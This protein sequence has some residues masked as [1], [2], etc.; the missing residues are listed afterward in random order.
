M[1]LFDPGSS[2]L[3]PQLSQVPTKIVTR[4]WTY[5]LSLHCRN[6]T[7]SM[8]LVTR[9]CLQISQMVGSSS[10]AIALSPRRRPSPVTVTRSSRSIRKDLIAIGSVVIELGQKADCSRGRNGEHSLSAGEGNEPKRCPL[11]GASGLLS[12]YDPDQS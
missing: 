9:P 11:L 12:A 8:C 3:N 5:P 2:D 6:A 1:S 7:S 4:Q 10:A